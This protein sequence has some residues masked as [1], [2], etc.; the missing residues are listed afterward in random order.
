MQV[1]LRRKGMNM[2]LARF[3]DVNTVTDTKN[4]CVVCFLLPKDGE[5]ID[6]VPIGCRR[7]IKQ[8]NKKKAFQDE[9]TVA[10]LDLRTAVLTADKEQTCSIRVWHRGEGEKEPR[11][12]KIGAGLP[13]NHGDVILFGPLG[14]VQR[15][16]DIDEA[17]A[18]RRFLV[19]INWDLLVSRGKNA[20]GSVK[21]PVH[22]LCE[23]GKSQITLE[24][25]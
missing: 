11:Y 17:I 7:G 1:R 14:R 10:V 22:D 2:V 15:K 24:P 5:N 18:N 12:V 25:Y 4:R 8:K 19:A 23:W 9:P 20:F 6:V 3:D 21:C 16:M 13:I